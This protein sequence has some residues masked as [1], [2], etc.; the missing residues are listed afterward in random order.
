MTET[1]SVQLASID[2]GLSEVKG[3][4]A[5]LADEIR[6]HGEA[7]TRILEILTPEQEPSGQPL[8]ELITQLIGRLDRQS[9]ML[10]EI[11]TGQGDLARTLPAEVANALDDKQGAGTPASGAGGNGHGPGAAGGAA[12]PP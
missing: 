1:I 3:G 2:Q 9:Y 6:L 5:L 4:I 7:L 8:H 10:R 11:L 12:S